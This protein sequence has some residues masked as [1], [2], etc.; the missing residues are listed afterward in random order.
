MFFVIEYATQRQVIRSTTPFAT[1]E[2]V[3]ASSKMQQKSHEKLN[4]FNTTN[5]FHRSI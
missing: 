3:H 4:Q 1:I 5:E 2:S